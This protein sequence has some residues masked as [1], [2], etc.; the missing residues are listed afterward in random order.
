[1]R[2]RVPSLPLHFNDLTKIRE[3]TK[4][5]HRLL[6]ALIDQRDTKKLGIKNYEG[7]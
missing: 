1:M 6:V 4:R 5:E 3:Y 2:R 7:K